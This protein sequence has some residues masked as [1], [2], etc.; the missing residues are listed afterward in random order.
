MKLTKLTNWFSDEEPE[1]NKHKDESPLPV[2]GQQQLEK[3]Q[4]KI[5][6]LNQDLQQSQKE[7]AQTKAQLQIHKGFQIELG[8]AQLQLQQANAELQRYKKN[9]FEQQKELSATKAKYQ[10]VEQHLAKLSHEQNWLDQLKTPIEV[11]KIEKT[12]PKQDFETLWGFGILSPT[13]EA[14]ITNGAI[15][16]KGWVLGKKAPAR[17]IQVRYQNENLL[18]TPVKL[19]RPVVAQQYPDIP[20]ANNSGFEFSLAIAGITTEIELILEALLEDETVVSLCNFVLQPKATAS[21][22]T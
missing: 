14:V 22:D 2:Q 15:V 9:L 6:R 19:R 3:S 20:A 17:K 5:E 7:L 11:I 12:L 1:K 21:N 16:V 4:L 13:S 18:A 8:E 10:L